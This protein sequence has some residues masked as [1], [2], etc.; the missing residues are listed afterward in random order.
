MLKS[1]LEILNTSINTT[2]LTVIEKS[3]LIDMKTKYS[4]NFNKYS[5]N[6]DFVIKVLSKQ[7]LEN[8]SIMKE[9]D[10]NNNYI[11]SPLS[12]FYGGKPFNCIQHLKNTIRFVYKTKKNNK[13]IFKSIYIWKNNSVF[14]SLDRIQENIIVNRKFSNSK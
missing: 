14:N 13:V 5:H 10:L 6:R 9:E 4:Y 2:D 11:T 12:I 3:Q 1:K 7:L 8:K